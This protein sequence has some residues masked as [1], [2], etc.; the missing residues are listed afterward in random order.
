VDVGL[1]AGSGFVAVVTAFLLR[2][3]LSAATVVILLA[4]AGAGVGWGAMLLQPDPSTGEVVAA[5]VILAV[6]VPA[7]VRIV[8]GPFGPR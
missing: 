6:L 5:I 2:A 8:L 3:R 7:H 1:V 4:A